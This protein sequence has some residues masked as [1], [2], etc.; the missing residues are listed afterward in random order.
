[1]VGADHLA[2]LGTGRENNSN[3]SSMKVGILEQLGHTFWDV[4]HDTCYL[5]FSGHIANQVIISQGQA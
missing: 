1:M 2:V 4:I 3:V 5:D